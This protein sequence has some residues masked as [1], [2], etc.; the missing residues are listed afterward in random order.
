MQ[1]RR[2]R[3]PRAATS[4]ARRLGA[5]LMILLAAGCASQRPA[6]Q[7]ANRPLPPGYVVGAPSPQW[8]TPA[9][10]ISGS[11]PVYPIGQLLNGRTGHAKVA[12]TV[13]E[14]GT[15][16]DIAVGEATNAVF[17]RHAAIAVK[18]WR[19]EPAMKDGRPVASRLDVDLGFDILRNFDP[20]PSPAER[21]G[22]R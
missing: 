10:L 9:R 4:A 18:G 20:P 1:P 7:R 13:A 16:R 14:D 15:T 21:R 2:S 3:A 19:F 22:E 5:G 6:E 11:A 17:G 12:F 8:D